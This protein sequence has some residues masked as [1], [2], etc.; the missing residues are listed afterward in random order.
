MDVFLILF[1]IKVSC[2]F[3]L[4]SLHRGDSNEYT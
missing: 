2:V 1:N 3:L 4:E